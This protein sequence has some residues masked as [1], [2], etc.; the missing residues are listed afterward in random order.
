MTK[1]LPCGVAASQSRRWQETRPF[2]N[3][4]GKV[5]P[6]SPFTEL[7]VSRNF[8]STHKCRSQLERTTERPRR[9]ETQR[10]RPGQLLNLYENGRATATATESLAPRGDLLKPCQSPTR[11]G[12]RLGVKEHG[13]SRSRAVS[14]ASELRS[15]SAS[16]FPRLLRRDGRISASS[17]RARSVV[18]TTE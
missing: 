11:R 14:A 17:L 7:E 1:T 3:S 15:A 2:L 10:K 8:R 4:M 18:H 6:K 16:I 5:C 13:P 12:D 9:T